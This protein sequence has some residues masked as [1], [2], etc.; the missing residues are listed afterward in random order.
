[1]STKIHSK[2][3]LNALILEIN[4]LHASASLD[5]ETEMF[6]NW[7]LSVAVLTANF[8]TCDGMYTQNN[9]IIVKQCFFNIIYSVNLLIGSLKKFN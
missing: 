4:S 6:L 7:L 8:Y 2:V 5:G 9:I 3:Y 1:M